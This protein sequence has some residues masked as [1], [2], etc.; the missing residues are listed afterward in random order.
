MLRRAFFILTLMLLFGFGQQGA[1]MHAVTHLADA[2]EQQQDKKH[3]APCEQCAAYAELANAMPGV[4]A[5]TVPHIP[6][7][8][9]VAIAG[10]QTADLRHLLIYPARAPPFIS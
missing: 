9:I 7:E 2:Q 6:C 3:N 10:T 4:V 8:H 1:F 5:Y